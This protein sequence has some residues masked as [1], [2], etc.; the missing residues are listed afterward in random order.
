MAYFIAFHP[1]TIWPCQL[2]HLKKGCTSFN[3]VPKLKVLD[4]AISVVT[5][6]FTWRL[7]ISSSSGKVILVSY[8]K[9]PDGVDGV[10]G[11]YIILPK[12]TPPVCQAGWAWSPGTAFGNGGLYSVLINLNPNIPPSAW[13]VGFIIFRLLMSWCNITFLVS[14]LSGIASACC[15]CAALFL[16]FWLQPPLSHNPGL[17]YIVSVRLIDP[18]ESLS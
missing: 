15:V 1:V 8:V 11:V 2:S 4:P 14:K 12:V 3:H 13:S 16:I 7:S 5:R 9:Y 6:D 10:D 18:L 17:E